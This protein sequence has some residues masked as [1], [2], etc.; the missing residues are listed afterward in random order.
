MEDGSLLH[1]SL[2]DLASSEVLAI[3]NRLM[4][5]MNSLYDCCDPC[6]A[7]RDC[8]CC[9][10]TFSTRS[11]ATQLPSTRSSCLPPVRRCNAVDSLHSILQIARRKR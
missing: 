11:G 10:A 9:A 7:A 5:C 3:G 4:Q 6:S 2:I 1:R 8:C